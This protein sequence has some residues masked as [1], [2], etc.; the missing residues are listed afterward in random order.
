M[1][2]PTP[3]LQK[4][5]Q[6]ADPAGVARLA[7]SLQQL[8]GDAWPHLR[9]GVAVSGG[10]DSMALLGLMHRLVPGHV[11]AATVDHGL[12][13]A[14]ADEAEMVACWCAA[15][16]VHHE[17]LR[18]ARPITGSLQAAARDARYALLDQWRSA[19]G[20]V[21]IM[22]AHH[23][24]DQLE[25][26]VMRLNRSS[27]VGGLAGVRA[28][29]GPLLRPLLG[30]RRSE[31]HDWATAHAMPF[32]ED[33]A[34][35]DA[36][37]DRARLR[38]ALTGQTIIDVNAAARSARWLDQADLALD[39]MT[40]QVMAAWP[41]ADD[42]TVIRDDRYP[43]EL[44]RRIVS[45]RLRSNQPGLTLRGVALDGVI[46][47][48]RAGRRAMVGHLLID[49]LRPAGASLWRITKAPGRKA[50]QK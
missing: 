39:W 45:H 36:R 24:D 12:R 40:T 35:A 18:P 21:H 44:F 26:L 14:S 49:P 19:N 9:Y 30:W 6:A 13:A 15:H 1:S 2:G 22:T 33:P 27:G 7:D 20:L 31:L 50:A 43:D 4:P 23:A 17:I 37:F 28:V 25:T 41:D 10:G 46:L 32:V 42:L 47:A 5:K 3:R 29:Q 34:N 16:D 11:W 38:R 48:M 8:V